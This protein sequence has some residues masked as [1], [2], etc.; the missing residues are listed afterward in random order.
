MKSSIEQVYTPSAPEEPG[1][2]T[3][4]DRSGIA[5]MKPAS[6][7]NA[8][9][10][11]K[12]GHEP[13]YRESMPARRFTLRAIVQIARDVEGKFRALMI[14]HLTRLH[15]LVPASCSLGVPVVPAL[16]LRLRQI[17]SRPRHPYP[18]VKCNKQGYVHL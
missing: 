9:L 17:R 4:P 11:V 16:C 18:L 1:D 14:G 12:A 15:R 7:V 6:P 2:G 13:A 8:T 3:V 5:P 10:Q